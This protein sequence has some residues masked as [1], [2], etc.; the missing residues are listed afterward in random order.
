MIQLL[1]KSMKMKTKKK[2][3]FNSSMSIV[4]HK[5]STFSTCFVMIQL[6]VIDNL[7]SSKQSTTNLRFSNSILIHPRYSSW[8]DI[9]HHGEIYWECIGIN[10][11]TL[12]LW[13]EQWHNEY[14]SRTRGLKEASCG[15]AKR[16]LLFTCEG[17]VSKI[18]LDVIGWHA[19]IGQGYARQRSARCVQGTTRRKLQQVVIRFRFHI[20]WSPLVY[21]QHSIERGLLYFQIFYIYSTW[22]FDATICFYFHSNTRGMIFFIDEFY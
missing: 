16:A 12:L 1:S 5:I 14:Y 3:T 17:H 21:L 11:D 10:L 20:P 6:N 22:S 13:I 9:H 19:L 18:F 8:K 7:A 2:Q 15:A 4:N